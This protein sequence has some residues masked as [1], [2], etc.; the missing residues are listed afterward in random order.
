MQRA[1]TTLSRGGSSLA[2]RHNRLVTIRA[3]R[4][5][6]PAAAS[7]YETIDGIKLDKNALN[8]A[9]EA[10]AGNGDGRISLADAKLILD[11]LSGDGGGVTAIEFRTA[12]HILRSFNFTPE[13]EKS[14]V[15]SLAMSHIR[16]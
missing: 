14:F 7:Y 10:V 6:A 12:F 13:A 15:A 11:A 5:T 3:L 16:S 4:T 2:L 1:T 8:A 9:R